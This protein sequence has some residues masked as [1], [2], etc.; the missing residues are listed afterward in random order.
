M[1]CFDLQLSYCLNGSFEKCIVDTKPVIE[2]TFQRLTTSST[3]ISKEEMLDISEDYPFDY[4]FL[5][6]NE[7][8]E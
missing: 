1:F 4:Q 7:N 3:A 2:K 6:E 5:Q 8:L